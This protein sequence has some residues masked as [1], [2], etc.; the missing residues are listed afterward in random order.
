MITVNCPVAFCD[1]AFLFL[2]TVGNLLHAFG[3]SSLFG[4]RNVDESSNA[5]Y[6]YPVENLI[7]F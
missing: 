5:V 7:A 4:A 2:G 6:A 3:V 1:G